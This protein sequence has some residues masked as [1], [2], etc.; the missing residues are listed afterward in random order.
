LRAVSALG[1]I[2]VSGAGTG[3]GRAT[4]NRLV[5][6][7]WDVLAVGRRPEPL[8][9]LAAESSRRVETIAADVATSAGARAVAECL[10][11]AGLEC[12]GIVAA[13]GALSSSGDGDG[14]LDGAR[15][16]WQATFESNVLT[17]VS[18]V[19]ALRESLQRGW[20]SRAVV[21]GATGRFVN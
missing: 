19:E 7:G 3:I 20:A 8:Q 5:A 9:T 2:V 4:A 16:D 21:L 15:A 10:A 18:L 11:A 1:A 6:D 14:G 12:R 17:A 13:T